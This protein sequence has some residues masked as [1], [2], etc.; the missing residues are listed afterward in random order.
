MSNLKAALTES[1]LKLLYI[2][3]TSKEERH[4]YIYKQYKLQSMIIITISEHLCIGQ[5]A[6]FFNSNDKIHF[7]DYI[8]KI[9]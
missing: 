7:N 2:H 1:F 4:I 6:L 9:C 3:Q 8:K 5:S